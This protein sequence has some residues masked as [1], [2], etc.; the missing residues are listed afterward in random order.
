M[1]NDYKRRPSLVERQAQRKKVAKKKRI[2]AFKTFCYMIGLMTLF[3]SVFCAGLY[4]LG[5]L[6]SW[7]EPIMTSCIEFAIDHE[8]TV[9]F[10]VAILGLS[11]YFYD[12]IKSDRK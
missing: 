11:V 12:Y 10:V 2:K 8:F 1:N 7:A 4:A 9:M 5:T 3:M 6:Y